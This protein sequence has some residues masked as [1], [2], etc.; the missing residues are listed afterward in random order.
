MVA[1]NLPGQSRV[2]L[3]V[4][5]CGL[6]AETEA[7]AFGDQWSATLMA[8]PLSF[9]ATSVSRRDPLSL[10]CTKT[11]GEGSLEAGV[12]LLVR[13]ISCLNKFFFVSFREV[14][15]CCYLLCVHRALLFGCAQ[16]LD[17]SQPPI[18]WKVH[19]LRERRGVHTQHFVFR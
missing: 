15:E 4:A 2:C 8:L 19:H 7:G 11:R 18:D 5:F 12:H 1:E 3:V 14:T 9:R 13:L 16:A 6:R 17:S 10:S